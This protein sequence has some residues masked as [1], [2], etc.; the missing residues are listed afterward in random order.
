MGDLSD[1]ED[2]ERNMKPLRRLSPDVD[3]GLNAVLANR[4]ISAMALACYARW[5]ELETWMRSTVYLELK[6]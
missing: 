2:L 5:W 4:D 3:H 6:C 1:D